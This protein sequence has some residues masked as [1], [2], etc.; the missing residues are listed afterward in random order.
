ML[1][2]SKKINNLKDNTISDSTI[3]QISSDKLEVDKLFIVDQLPITKPSIIQEVLEGIIELSDHDIEATEPDIRPY[4]IQEKI[5]YNEIVAYKESYEFYMS[6]RHIIAHRLKSLENGKNPLASKRLYKFVQRIYSKHCHH[7]N[8][9]IRIKC[10]NEE[11]ESNLR[12]IEGISLDDMAV[13]AS[14]VFYVFSKCHIFHKP[15]IPT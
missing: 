7:K 14:I 11:I 10:V 5:D 13:V 4:T 12:R 8:P 1:G 9:D 15:P 3:N 6:D 2:S